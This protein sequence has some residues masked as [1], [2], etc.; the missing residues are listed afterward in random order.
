[1]K[2]EF[3]VIGE[4]TA[5]ARPRLNMYTGSI[6]TPTKTKD[7]ENLIRQ[8]FKLKYK[9]HKVLTGRI[10]VTIIA[11]FKVPKNTSKKKEEEMLN[12]TVSPTKKPD[13]DNIEKIVLD[14]MNKFVFEDDSQI[15][16]ISVEKV[17]SNEEKIYVSIEEY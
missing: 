5:K 9:A 16:K 6:Y 13:I 15:T 17:Y 4:I 12:G 8:Y 10:N 14:A 1:M 2:Y 11:Y 3:E 7:Y